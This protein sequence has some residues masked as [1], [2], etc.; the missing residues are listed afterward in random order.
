MRHAWRITSRL[1]ALLNNP[2]V[3]NGNRQIIA[4]GGGLAMTTAGITLA[5]QNLK[6]KE[7]CSQYKEPNGPLKRLLSFR[8]LEEVHAEEQ[9]SKTLEK[10]LPSNAYPLMGN[11]LHIPPAQWDYNWDKRNPESLVKPLKPKATE[12]EVEDYQNSI[13]EK[14][15][16]VQRTY[17]LVRHG[18]YEMKDTDEERILTPLGREQANLTG[19]RLASLWKH[20]EEK[21][22]KGL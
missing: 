22:N 9:V 16:T 6:P 17:I 14:T 2:S 18:Q 1:I 5:Y 12:E 4:I 20:I 3:K 10:P 13:K 8:W 15:P 7:G 21:H 19:E 11:S